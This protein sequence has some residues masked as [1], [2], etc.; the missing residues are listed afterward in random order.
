MS[1]PSSGSKNKPRN[2]RERGGNRVDLHAGFVFRSCSSDDGWKQRRPVYI[3][4][5]QEEERTNLSVIKFP[6]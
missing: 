1:P 4:S 6:A 3:N 2:H 5:C